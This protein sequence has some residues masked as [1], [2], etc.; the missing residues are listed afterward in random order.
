M[1]YRVQKVSTAKEFSD[2]LKIPYRIYK[3]DENWIA[4]LNSEIRRSLNPKLNPYFKNASLELFI[5]Y[6]NEI[7]VSRAAVV[8]NKLYKHKYNISKALFGYFESM[9]DIAAVK[10]LFKTIEDYC[11]DMNVELIE[12]PFNP[13]HY[14]ELGIKTDKFDSLPAFF[15]THNPNYYS[16]LLEEAGFNISKILHTRKNDNV[17][18]YIL[19]KYGEVKSLDFEGYRVRSFSNKNFKKDLEAVREIFNDAFE[20]NW[21]FLPVSKEEYLFSAKL[22]CVPM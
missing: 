13:N 21:N 18:E 4:P 12:G 9:N 22:N 3:N 16:Y 11:R 19:K 1:S 14:S 20:N 17:N 7:P 10:T 5:C 15:Q 6:D 2:F 8:I